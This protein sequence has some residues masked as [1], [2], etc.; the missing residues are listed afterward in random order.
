MTQVNTLTLAISAGIVALV[1]GAIAFTLS[2]NLWD[3][4]G[5]PMPGIQVLLFPGNLTLIHVWHPLFTEEVSFWP[6]L[7]LLFIGQ[8]VVVTLVAALFIGPV[9]KFNCLFA[10][11][12]R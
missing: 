4:W 6:K 10:H 1:V 5:G 11:A 12:N 3:Y 7:A 2:W 9:R 8:F